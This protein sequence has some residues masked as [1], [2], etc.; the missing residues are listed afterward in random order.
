MSASLLSTREAARFLRVSEASIR[1]W[2]DGGLLPASRVGRR[3][4]R[5]FN[6]ADLLR[7]MGADP[8]EAA[9][10]ALRTIT[11]QGMTVG[12]G[13]HLASYFASDGGRLRLGV[14]FLGDGLQ[15]GQPCIV[16]AS[17]S[18]REHYLRAL[19]DQGVEVDAALRSGLLSFMPLRRMSLAAF[20]DVLDGMV[21][22]ASSRHPGPLRFLGEPASG[23]KSVGSTRGLLQLEQ[24]F[25]VMVKRLPM[26]ML[27][28]Y[29]V[30]EFN[31]V[32]LLEGLKLHFDTFAH[33]LGYFLN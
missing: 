1:R 14:P 3:R 11:L 10:N 13:S 33:P 18:A 15:S 31:G 2:T 6:Q 21:V 20:I 24:L 32:T 28:P 4:A 5:R 26:V 19:R 12:V 17:M 7:F 9:P 30:R 27:C 22:A 16:H 29:D 25:S 23:A 8:A